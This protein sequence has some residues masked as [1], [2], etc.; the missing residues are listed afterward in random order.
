LFLTV[1]TTKK[2][3]DTKPLNN[4][5]NVADLLVGL[6]IL[7]GQMAAILLEL[8]HLDMVPLLGR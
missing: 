8:A 6:Q 4:Q 1:G 2:S 5:V 3:I 7:T